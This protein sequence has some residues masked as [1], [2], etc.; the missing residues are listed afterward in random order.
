VA[1]ARTIYDRLAR[2]RP[3]VGLIHRDIQQPT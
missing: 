3:G 1:I 2:R